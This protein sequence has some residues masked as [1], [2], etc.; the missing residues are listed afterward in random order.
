[1]IHRVPQ[2][3]TSLMGRKSSGTLLVVSPHSV[4]A[5]CLPS[6]NCFIQ[7]LQTGPSAAATQAPHALQARS[8]APREQCIGFRTGKCH[9]AVLHCG[10]P[11]HRLR[12]AHQHRVGVGDNAGVPHA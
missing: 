7:Q 3:T 8:G 5:I 6:G 12:M 9:A 11:Q 10:N 2:C 1:M 4:C